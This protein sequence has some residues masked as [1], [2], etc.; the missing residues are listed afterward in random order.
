MRITAQTIIIVGVLAISGPAWSKIP[1][2]YKP[3]PVEAPFSSVF[4][5]TEFGS[6]A[7]Q[8]TAARV[9]PLP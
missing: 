6:Q 5:V 3:I 4:L 7:D 1:S 9:E 8:A 2:S